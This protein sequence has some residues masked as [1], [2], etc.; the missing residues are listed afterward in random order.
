MDALMKM[1]PDMKMMPDMAAPGVTPT[2][3][4]D[5]MVKDWQDKYGDMPDI[6]PLPMQDDGPQSVPPLPAGA[7]VTDAQVEQAKKAE[8]DEARAAEVAVQIMAAR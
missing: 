3:M 4:T 5:M 2:M 7:Q 1:T 6:A 8:M